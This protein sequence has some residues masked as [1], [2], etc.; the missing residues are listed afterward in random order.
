MD[1]KAS[2]LFDRIWTVNDSGLAFGIPDLLY[3]TVI[4]ALVA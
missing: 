1:N 4:S 2:F 3:V